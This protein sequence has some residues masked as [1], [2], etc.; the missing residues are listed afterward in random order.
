MGQKATIRKLNRYLAKVK[1]CQPQMKK[2]SDEELQAMT[3]GF[4]KRLEK[5]QSLEDILP[6]AFAAICEADYRVLGMYPY[7]V[8]ILGGIGLHFGYMCEMNTGEGKT[9]SATMPLYLNALTGRSTILVTTNDYLAKRDCEEMGPVYRFMGLTVGAGVDTKDDSTKSDGNKHKKEVYSSDIVYTT[10]GNL[11]FDYLFNNLVTDADSRFLRDFYYVIIDEADA[12]L[13]DAAQMPL[14]VAG[15]PRVQSNLYFMA[16]F[17]ITTL[18]EGVDYEEEDGATWLTES[19]I[20][21]AEAF[22]GIDNFYAEEVFEINRHVNIALKA[23]VTMTKG[24]N[25]VVTDDKKV[26]LLDKETGR[27][28]HGIK[29][30]GG[31]NQAI[32]AKEG[33]EPTQEMRS[34]ASVTYQNL[35]G[36]FEKIAGMSGTISNTKSELKN[37]YGVDTVVI[38]PNKPVKRKDYPDRF[39]PNKDIQLD[40]AVKA[41]VLAHETGQPVLVVAAAIE[42]TNEISARL[43]SEKIPHNVLNANNANWEASIIKEAG[44]MGAVTVATSMAGRGTDIKLGKGVKELGGLIV[45]GVGRM[46]NKRLERQA[47]GR[48]GRQGDP[49][50]SR[51]YVSLED[52]I[53]G[54]EDDD[55]KM[56]R[57]IERKRKISKRKLAKI[58]NTA[59]AYKEEMSEM[60]RESSKAYDSVMKKQ[61]Q[62]IYATRDN[63]I[64]GGT[65]TKEKFMA[66]AHSVVDEYISSNKKLTSE[67]ISRFTLDNLSYR[68]DK[69]IEE[70]MLKKKKYIRNYLYDRVD[71]Y[72][73]KKREAFGDDAVFYDFVRIVILTSIDNEWVDEVD[74]LQQLQSAVS[75]RASAQRNPVFEYQNDALESYHKMEKR[76]FKNMVRN[77]LL[78]DV[79]VDEN[80]IGNIIYP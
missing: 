14:V 16:D 76:V 57:Y 19:G 9:L 1:K 8:Q 45:I 43:I 56:Q 70:K 50:M 22:Y 74:Y 41:T 30:R 68:L 46:S 75:G 49:G 59:Q 69:Q 61:R 36:L 5:G 52:E 48:A 3:D 71:Y 15:A 11:G 2:C 23:H 13:L 53:V 65:I 17:F 77:V 66:I 33:I 64:D 55:K 10:N 62:L 31:M 24:I 25:Y 44:Q 54:V 4:K 73:E 79:I 72:Y 6:E 80:G 78:S 67:M 21:A 38:P 58:I 47:R 18:E 63:L 12:V 20:A 34:V 51:F 28:M 26:V 35:F 32:E 40:A 42:D 29:I 7:D 60:G 27:Q 39:F 37:I